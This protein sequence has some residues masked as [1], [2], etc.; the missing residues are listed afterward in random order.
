MTKKHIPLSHP[1]YKSLVIRE[2]L[3][4]GFDE[5][6]VVEQG[7]IAHG[8]GEAFDY[9]LGEKTTIEASNAIKVAAATLIL[10][11]NPVISVNG[12]VAALVPKEI[13]TLSKV[14][15][16]KIEVNLFHRTIEREKKIK[17]KLIFYGANEVLG[18]GDKA[19][20]TILDLKSS[21]RL[22]DPK[23]IFIADTVLVPLEDGD[24]TAA[25][26]KAGK[27]VITIDLNPLSRTSKT[28]NITI[29]DNVVRAI[30][31]LI[32]DVKKL[33][34]IDKEELRNIIKRFDNKVN[35]NKCYSSIVKGFENETI[36]SVNTK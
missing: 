8:R 4:K 29:I 34:D 20:A 10:S 1:R 26:I 15:G 16:A 33:Y 5:G 36:S 32:N 25:L 17:Q 22:V 31:L 27:T 7:L 12:N 23:G 14:L 19:S 28:A 24:R 2:L 9:L 6:I 30:P 35:R 3:K 11:K 13:V 18:I 21:R